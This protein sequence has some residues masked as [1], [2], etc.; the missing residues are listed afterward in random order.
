MAHDAPTPDLLTRLHED[1]KT[2]MKAGDREKLTTIRML[3]SEA[4]TADLQKPPTTPEKMIEAHYKRLRKSRE[5]YQRLDKPDEVA[6]LDREIAIAEQY[7][8]KQASPGET[9]AL[10]DAFL[11]ENPDFTSGDVGR[12]TGLFMKQHGGSVDPKAANA[13]IREVLGG[14]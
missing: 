9:N 13:R 14:R 3:L 1:M 8:P 12:A 7:V 11:A 4:R 6:A 5:E 10:V 2:A